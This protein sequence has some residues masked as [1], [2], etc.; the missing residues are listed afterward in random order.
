MIKVAVSGCNGRMGKAVVQAVKD[1]DDL[2]LVCGIDPADK[3]GISKAGFPV[4]QSVTDALAAETFDVMVDFS[5]PR[6]ALGN[7]KAALDQ[8]VDCV[9][10]T[11]GND[12]ASMRA[13]L[14]DAPLGTCLF[15]A[16]NFTTGAVLMMQFA[17][18]AA[19]FFPQVEIIEFHHCNKRDAPSG[20]AATTAHLIASARDGAP[21]DAP[22]KETE[23]DEGV[24]ARGALIDG[25]P[26]HSVRTMGN[27][28]DQEVLFGSYGQTLSI[29][30]T[31]WDTGSYMPGVLLGIRSV[32]ELSGYVE[33]LDALMGID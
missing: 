5:I 17:K 26:V 30:H 18:I 3:D 22:G 7:V 4:Y 32:G 27:V 9:L 23:T 21:S 25:I 11:T 1:A 31:S 12:V 29:K 2:T 15:Y 6:A 10:G 24:C 19:P 14:D 13:T 33:G 28:A 20:T 8:G 16:P